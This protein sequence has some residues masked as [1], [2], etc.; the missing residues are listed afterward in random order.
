VASRWETLQ[1][2]GDSMEVFMDTPGGV[3]PHPGVIVIMHG[4]GLDTFTQTMVSRLAEQGYAAAAPNVYHR[5]KDYD[6]T[7]PAAGQRRPEGAPSRISELRDPEIEADV[8]ATLAH[9]HR[10]PDV[11]A[12]PVG[13]TG[14]CMGGRIVY[15]MAALNAELRAGAVF[16]GGNIMGKWADDGPTPF[17][18]TAGI[19]CPIAGFFGAD[20]SNPSPDDV[21]KIDAEL[22][23]HGKEHRFH[24]YP[25]T[26][27]SF[28]DFT[29]ELAYREEAA[30][31]SWARL[32]AFFSEHLKVAVG[33]R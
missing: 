12:A 30:N 9:L 2:D 26:G 32:L 33:S 16:Y 19:G 14:F 20:D 25:R 13:I 6:P 24:S 5:Q 18:L 23:K 10:L 28:Q 15:M 27:H 8:N 1:V 29:N 21:Q 17:G 4:P 7:K 11:G 3:G 31:D 22:T